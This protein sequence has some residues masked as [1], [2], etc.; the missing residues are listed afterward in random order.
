MILNPRRPFCVGLSE[1]FGLKPE[2]ERT[3]ENE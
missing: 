2:L 1:Q 3:H